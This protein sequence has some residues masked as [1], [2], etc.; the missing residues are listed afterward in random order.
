MAKK[1]YNE[2]VKERQALMEEKEME[3]LQRRKEFLD[4]E[5]ALKQKLGLKRIEPEFEFEND[6]EWLEHLKESLAFSIEHEKL[7]I[8]AQIDHLKNQADQRDEF[9]KQYGGK[10]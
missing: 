10:L 3:Y 2:K 5:L 8:D 4:K 1:T 6:P 9:D 7:Q